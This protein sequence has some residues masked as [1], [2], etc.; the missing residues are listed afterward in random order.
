MRDF[1]VLPDLVDMEIH[2]HNGKEFIRVRILPEM[3]GRFL[4]EFAPTCKMV[5]HSAPGV[6]ATRSSQYV[7]LK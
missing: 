4:G 3:V 1:I 7:P 2:V 5:K 6:G